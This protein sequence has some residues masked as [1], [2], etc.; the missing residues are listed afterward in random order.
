MNPPELTEQVL[1]LLRDSSASLPDLAEAVV[2][3]VVA[4]L[5]AERDRLRAAI[6]VTTLA[7]RIRFTQGEAV[8]AIA[9]LDGS[10]IEEEVMLFV[11]PPYLREGNRLYAN[12]MTEDEHRQLAQ[13]LNTSPARWLLTYDDEDVVA[14]V[15][16]PHRRVLAYQIPN[17]A[18]RARIATEHAVLSDNLWLPQETVLLPGS[19]S[20][21]VREHPV[22]A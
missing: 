3:E 16:Y 8:T 1:R 20:A 5:L 19:S 10:G 18:N 7:G 21:W 2:E 17:T 15:L 11:D 9:D 22:A 14:Q 12:G 4:P 13:V 6:G